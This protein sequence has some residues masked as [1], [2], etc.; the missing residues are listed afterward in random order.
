MIHSDDTAEKSLPLTPYKQRHIPVEARK[1]EPLRS[2]RVESNLP[3][4]Q[5]KFSD[6]LAQ[7]KE[8]MN[9]MSK[10]DI[11][12]ISTAAATKLRQMLHTA[13]PSMNCIKIGIQRKGCSGYAYTMDYAQCDSAHNSASTKPSSSGDLRVDKDG[14][15][16]IVDPGAIFFLSGTELDY[17][18]SDVEERFVFQNPNAKH[19]CGCGES[20]LV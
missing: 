7:L 2:I 17:I 4:V 6:R 8:R 19:Y 13:P 5:D 9:A 20:F 1:D 10:K 14:V 16:V 11:F 3:S 15:I 12:K 18:T